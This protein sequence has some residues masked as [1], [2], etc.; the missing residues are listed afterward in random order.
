MKDMTLNLMR[1]EGAK[2]SQKTRQRKRSHETKSSSLVEVYFNNFILL[3][4]NMLL[5]NFFITLYLYCLAYTLFL[6]NKDDATGNENKEVF[7]RNPRGLD[8]TVN[9][10]K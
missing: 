8:N 7:D 6:R 10:K 3:L 4:F 2:T 5:I 1:M 9:N